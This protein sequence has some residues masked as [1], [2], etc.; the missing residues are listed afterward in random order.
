MKIEDI[1]SDFKAKME[2]IGYQVRH[3]LTFDENG[4]IVGVK[5]QVIGRLE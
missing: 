2:S 4:E 5:F 1:I 3:L